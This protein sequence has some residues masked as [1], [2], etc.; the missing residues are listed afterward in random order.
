MPE[1]KTAYVLFDVDDTLLDFHKAEA[2]AL[3]RTLT[4]MGLDPRPEIISLYSRINAR[5]WELL[6]EGLLTREQVLVRRFDIFFSQLGIARSGQEAKELYEHYLSIGHYFVDGAPKLLEALKGKYELYI[7]SNGTA[8]VQAGRIGSAGIAQYF[9]RIFIS[10]EI[11]FNKPSREFFDRCFEEIP[12]FDRARAIIIGDR[13]TSDIRGGINAGIKT[14]WFNPK[15]EPGREDIK[16]DYE[17]SALSQ[18]P[19]LLNQIFGTS[20]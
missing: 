15:G 17:I 6:E 14:C 13:L 11:G 20:D 18:L 16:A 8:A 19:A 4:D 5:Q 3:T 12:G 1:K 10:E 2:A 9:R 7:V